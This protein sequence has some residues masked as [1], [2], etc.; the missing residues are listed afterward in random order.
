MGKQNGRR[1]YS[2]PIKIAGLFLRRLKT[3]ELMKQSSRKFKN[4]GPTDMVTYTIR[5]SRIKIVD[6]QTDRPT[7]RQTDRHGNVYYPLVANK[8]RIKNIITYQ[9]TYTIGQKIIFLLNL[10]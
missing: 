7:D 6:R 3:L 8:K 5:W 2:G 4:F 10:H 9:F 1:T